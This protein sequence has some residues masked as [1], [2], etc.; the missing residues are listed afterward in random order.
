MDVGE[1]LSYFFYTDLAEAL[2]SGRPPA[3]PMQRGRDVMAILEDDDVPRD[4]RHSDS[5][6]ESGAGKGK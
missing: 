6:P 1:E 5:T 2:A 3:I 4:A